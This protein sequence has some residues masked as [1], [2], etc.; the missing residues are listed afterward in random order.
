MV[1]PMLRIL[2]SVV[3]IATPASSL[4]QQTLTRGSLQGE[5]QGQVAESSAGK[6][7]ERQTKA[8]TVANIK[9]MA[10]VNSRIHNRV[11]NRIRNRIDRNYD[12]KANATSPFETATDRLRSD[13]R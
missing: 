2:L 7:G 1:V 6:V 13:P 11:E 4:A 8:A 9:P 12:P 5:R 3:A 10:R